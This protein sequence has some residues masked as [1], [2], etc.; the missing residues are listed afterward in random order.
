MF[1]LQIKMSFEDWMPHNSGKSIY[2]TEKGVEL[3][4]GDF[5]SGT[6]FEATIELDV[7]SEKE[8]K[9]AIKQGFNPIFRIYEKSRTNR[10]LCHN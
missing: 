5:H 10:T 3:S 1:N 9:E 7:D 2:S 4:M 6:V 8:L